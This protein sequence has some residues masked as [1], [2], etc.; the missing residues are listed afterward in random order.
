ML[1]AAV[2]NTSAWYGVETVVSA[3]RRVALPAFV[4]MKLSLASALSRSENEVAP[5]ISFETAVASRSRALTVTSPTLDT[6][7]LSLAS[8]LSRTLKDVAPGTSLDTA[9]PNRRRNAER[10]VRSPPI[11]A[12]AV[13]NAPIVV[14]AKLVVPLT[15]NVPLTVS[16][17]EMLRLPVMPVV[18]GASGAG[19]FTRT[20]GDVDWKGPPA[21]GM[22][23]W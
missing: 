9:A 1:S 15:V 12:A 6:K 16:L 7:R 14:P 2:R 21:D 10:M 11:L 13:V 18:A 23:I 5:G 3:P 20:D 22:L 19:V 4:T 8:A 17:P